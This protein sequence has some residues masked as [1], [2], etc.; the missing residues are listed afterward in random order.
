MPVKGETL[1]LL[2]DP[3]LGL[4]HGSHLGHS[5]GRGDTK[6]HRPARY[7]LDKDLHRWPGIR[8]GCPTCRIPHASPQVGVKTQYG[9]SPYSVTLK[10]PG[11]LE[12]QAAL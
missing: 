5:L 10:G 7:C 2:W 4:N 3:F 8:L 1:P 9:P 11:G 6:S 12:W